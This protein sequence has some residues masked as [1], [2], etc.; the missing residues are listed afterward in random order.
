MSSLEKSET[1]LFKYI[2][3]GDSFVGKSKILLRYTNNSYNENFVITIGA[4]FG[5]KTINIDGQEIRIQIWD[6]AGMENF[7]SITRSYYKNSI[8]ALIVYDISNKDSFKNV[9][10]WIEDCKVFSPKNIL[11][12]LIGNKCDLEE[13]RQVFIEEGKKVA[14]ENDMIFFETSA[15][16]NININEVFL[17]SAQKILE[18][19]KNNVYEEEE[20]LITYKQNYNTKLNN[21]ESIFKNLYENYCC[22]N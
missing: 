11:L 8:C 16:D 15:K 6:T 2:I 5:A 22:S 10:N 12:V 13:K 21:N 18:N 19:I 7:K 20:D 14:E 1:F 3:I 9:L 4:E 17:K